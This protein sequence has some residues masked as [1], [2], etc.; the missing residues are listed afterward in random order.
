MIL[1]RAAP[2]EHY[3]WIA[4]RAHLVIGSSF[5]A[6]EAIDEQGQI[7]AMVGYDGW[8]PNSCAMHVAIENRAA[9][10]RILRPAFGIPLVEA[11]KRL[12]IATVLSTNNKSLKLVKHLGFKPL[13]VLRDGW[14][15]GVGIHFFEM[16]REDCRWIG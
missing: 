16:R 9:G 6:I 11:K 15:E 2:P 1:V 13:C 7:A 10:R 4:R 12:V 8:M 5:R 14:A 3:D